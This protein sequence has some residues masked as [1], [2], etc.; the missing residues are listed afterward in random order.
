MED[1]IYHNLECRWTIGETK[2]HYQGLK[3]TLIGLE[4]CHPLVALSDTDIIVSPVHIELGEVAHTL[5]AMD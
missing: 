2:V 3:E 1:L 5:E 4:C